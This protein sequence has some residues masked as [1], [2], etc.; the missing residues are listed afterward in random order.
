M[1]EKLRNIEQLT[2]DHRSLVFSASSLHTVLVQV[3][4]SH[5]GWTFCKKSEQTRVNVKWNISDCKVVIN[6]LS[7]HVSL[8]CTSCVF[9]ED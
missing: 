7:V 8:N 1:C 4:A 5:Y 6:Q 2:P 9:N 3:F